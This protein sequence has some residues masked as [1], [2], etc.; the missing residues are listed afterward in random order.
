MD[1]KKNGL[2]KKLKKYSLQDIIS[3]NGLVSRDISLVKQKESQLLLLLLWD[4]PSEIGVYTG[5]LFEYLASK[6]AN[7]SNRGSKR[8]CK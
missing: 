1:Q 5:K 6:K 8:C 2:R 3:H 4:H 7:L